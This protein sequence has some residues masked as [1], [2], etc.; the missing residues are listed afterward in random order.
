[1]ITKKIRD[2][3]VKIVLAALPV[4]GGLSDSAN[5]LAAGCSV[6]AGFW[7][8]CL[9]FRSFAGWF[10]KRLRAPA[11]G[12]WVLTLVHAAWCLIGLPPYWGISLFLLLP[13]SLLESGRKKTGLGEIFWLG[14]GFFVLA[15]VTGMGQEVLGK[16]FLMRIFQTPAGT[17]LLLSFAAFFWQN[18]PSRERHGH[19]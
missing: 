1:M 15:A 5:A 6:L 16:R 8:T 4:L 17:L 11:L 12:L 10:P 18:Q 19:A 2:P 3:F 13:E 9:F 14:A 7:G